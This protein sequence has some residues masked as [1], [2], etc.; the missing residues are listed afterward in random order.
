MPIS[1]T[2]GNEFGVHMELRDFVFFPRLWR[3]ARG[4]FWH[5]AH[6]SF[7]A[8]VL[9]VLRVYSFCTIRK[10]SRWSRCSGARSYIRNLSL[11]FTSVLNFRLY[12]AE[13]QWLRRLS[14]ASWNG[15]GSTRESM[16]SN[17][18]AVHSALVVRCGHYRPTALVLFGQ[19]ARGSYH[20][21][22]SKIDYPVSQSEAFTRNR[23][24]LLWVKQCFCRE[25][26]CMFRGM[27]I[28]KWI[29]IV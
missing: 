18:R 17:V 24:W 27:R 2:N 5:W 25:T 3:L 26:E 4:V 16:M 8:D 23:N 1:F 7:S 20:N 9:L 29:P 10:S 6:T 12:W 13:Q 15:M 22:Q 21:P 19:I 28:A 14:F 11:V